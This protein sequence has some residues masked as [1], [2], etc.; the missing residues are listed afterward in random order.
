MKMEWPNFQ[1]GG[2]M[3][4]QFQQDGG[5]TSN[6][7]CVKV[8]TDE[9]MELLRKQIAVYA[10]ICEQLVQM[11]KVFSAQNEIAG[12]RMGNPYFDP[13]VASGSQK[14][15]A[16]QRWTPTP[17]Q[18]QILE[19]VYDECKGTPRKQKIQDM[20]AELAKHGQ[21]SETNVYNWFQ[22]RRARLKRKQS[23][24]VP[25]N[26][27]SEA[28]TVTHAESRKQNPESIQ[29]LEDSAPPPRDEDIYPQSPDLGIDQMIGKM[30]IPG[31]F[32]FHWQKCGS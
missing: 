29:S 26:A 24:V 14:L 25:N 15:T 9:Q 27:E 16:R 17:A 10:M 31:S 5:D 11:H 32:S 23:G 1:Q 28:E 19:H 21:I 30:E 18:L 13:F 20:T 22:N 2:E 7:L 12:M 4:R 8:M 6:G 3:E